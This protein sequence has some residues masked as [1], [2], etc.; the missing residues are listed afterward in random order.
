MTPSIRLRS[1]VLDCPDARALA[2]FYA[3]FA[4][5]TPED[6][7][8]EWVVLRLPDGPR[9]CFQ[10]APGHV[11]PRWPGA[12]RRT[13]ASTRTRTL[14]T[15][16]SGVA[17]GQPTPKPRRALGRAGR[18]AVW[19]VAGHADILRSGRTRVMLLLGKS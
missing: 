18:F 4:G 5:G 13:S 3:G 9:I 2:R 6:A 15:S 7:D 14:S 8:P 10:R 17:P 12:R 16:R 1:V 11:P 19:S